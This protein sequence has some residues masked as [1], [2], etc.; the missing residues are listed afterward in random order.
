MPVERDLAEVQAATQDVLLEGIRKV[1]V[2]FITAVHGQFVDVQLV[3]NVPL[4]DETTGT[5]FE[6]APALGGVP[7]CA[8]RGGGFLVWVPPSVNDSVLVIYT[9]L[10]YDSWRTSDGKTLVNPGW[11]GRHTAD[12]PFAIPMVAPDAKQLGSGAD[13]SKLVIGKDN[14]SAQI[15]ISGSDIELGNP[16]AD[17]VAL[18]TK[19]NAQLQSIGVTLASI[20]GASFGTPYVY[21]TLGSVASSLVKSG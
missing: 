9:D 7:V 21:A 11:C 5:T 4:F 13:S 2:G 16:A 20:A 14:S 15:K 12:S 18:A 17:F 6:A 3:T 10:S 8:I 1:A 19:V